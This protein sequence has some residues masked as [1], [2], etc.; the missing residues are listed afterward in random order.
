MQEWDGDTDEGECG[1]FPEKKGKL[2]KI[3]ETF[4]IFEQVKYLLQTFVLGPQQ[5]L[6]IQQIALLCLLN[7]NVGI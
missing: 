1:Q 2:F 3:S 7:L 6:W 4:K 5:H